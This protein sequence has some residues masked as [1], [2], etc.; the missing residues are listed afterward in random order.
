VGEDLLHKCNPGAVLI[1]LLSLACGHAVAGE[2]STRGFVALEARWFPDSPQFPGQESGIQ[3]SLQLAPELAFV[4]SDA[5]HRVRF[6]PYLRL[7]AWDSQRTHFDLREFS[8][9]WSGEKLETVVGMSK[10]F[11]GVAE[12]RHLVDI[13]N[14]TDLVD[15][16]D[17]EQ[18]L[19]QPMVSVATQQDWGRLT[20]FVLPFFRER[21]FAGEA[22]RLR[23]PLPVD[24]DK[25][26][27]ESSAGENHT[28]FAL[29]YAHYVGDWDIG[30]SLFS[31]TG[32]E[33][34]FVPDLAGTHLLPYYDQINQFGAYIQYTTGA[35][36]WKFEGLLR[37]GQGD[38]FGALV[39]GFEYTWYQLR[40]SAADLGWLLEYN[41]D[42]RDITAPPVLLDD[43]I[44]TGLRLTLNNMQDSTLL[45]GFVHDLDIGSTFLSLEAQHRIGQNWLVE[46]ES[47]WFVDADNRDFARFLDQDSYITVRLSRYF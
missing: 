46:V 26:Q 42:G 33:P 30:L 23:T 41:Y 14:Q 38:T 11:W 31:G 3:T 27:Y 32:R 43:D 12:S 21:T 9:R 4:S 34:R 44:F 25:P 8:W 22:G 40:G 7:D 2:F 15:N 35:W 5:H 37:E 47:F 19:G 28:D 39:A 17:H 36:L 20:L 29:R 24:T 18:K 45:A 16:F 1:T 10:V 13:I 6:D